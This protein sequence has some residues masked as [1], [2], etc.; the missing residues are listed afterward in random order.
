MSVRCDRCRRTFQNKYGFWGHQR[1]CRT[2]AEPPQPARS[3]YRLAQPRLEPEFNAPLGDEE[4]ELR[5]RRLTLQRRELEREEAAT[6]QRDLETL[7]RHINRQ[8][9]MTSRRDVVDEVC[10]PF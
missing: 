8:T 4:A 1:T 9:E 7:R 10:S 2:E 3:A 5:R 6:M